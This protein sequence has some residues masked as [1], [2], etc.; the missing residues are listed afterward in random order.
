M[1]VGL[2]MVATRVKASAMER[3][4]QE[5][6]QHAAVTGSPG[7]GA[8]NAGLYRAIWPIPILL[9]L[10][11]VVIG[12]AVP[13]DLPPLFAVIGLLGMALVLGGALVWSN[14]R[15]RRHLKGA[16]GEERIARTLSFL[17]SDYFVFHSLWLPGDAMGPKG[18]NDVDHLVVGPTGVYALETKNWN[19]EISVD[20]DGVK[21]NGRSPSRPPLQQVYQGARAVRELLL[22]EAGLPLH[23][24]PV[25]CFAGRDATLHAEVSGV[26]VCDGGNLLEVLQSA[27][28][29][30]L[31][32][33]K[34]ERIVEALQER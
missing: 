14:R 34:I 31:E 20:E 32:Q 17:P 33:G 24:R 18:P 10:A 27:Q 2:P 21:V 19:G 26:L 22:A 7:E 13:Y 9:L 5:N 6:Q 15:L 28:G 23:V 25:L 8:R 29:E 3:R 12:L 16:E 4:S 1:I 11:G 30:Q